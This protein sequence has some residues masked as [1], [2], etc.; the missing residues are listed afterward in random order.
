MED[1]QDIEEYVQKMVSSNK[2]KCNS[3][4]SKDDIVSRL[5]KNGP[6]AGRYFLTCSNKGCDGEKNKLFKW[7]TKK[8]H[9]DETDEMDIADDDDERP[10]KR[11]RTDVNNNTKPNQNYITRDELAGILN[12]MCKQLI[13]MNESMRMMCDLKREND[14]TKKNNDNISELNKST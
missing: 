11:K 4:K 10:R 2:Q 12:K 7:I 6:N 5:C 9:E 1:N 14:D 8:P 3:C 13:G